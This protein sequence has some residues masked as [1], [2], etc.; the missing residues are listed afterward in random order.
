MAT[1]ENPDPDIWTNIWLGLAAA[2]SWVL[3]RYVFIKER[4][5]APPATAVDKNATLVGIGAAFGDRL[6]MDELT[7]QVKRIAD[8]LDDK[9]QEKLVDGMDEIKQ[10]LEQLKKV[11]EGQKFSRR[12]TGNEE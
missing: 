11:E 8:I 2:I 5:Q 12:R 4:P 9:N 10:A 3:G 1:P 7:A 6:Q